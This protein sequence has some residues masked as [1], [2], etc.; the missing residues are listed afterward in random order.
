MSHNRWSGCNRPAAAVAQEKSDRVLKDACVSQQPPDQRSAPH[1]RLLR[2]AEQIVVGTTVAAA[3]VAMSAYWFSVG[4]HQGRL[5]D[6]DRA[7]PLTAEFKVDVNE[8]HWPEL[9]QLP[10]IGETLA[11]RIVDARATS[12]PFVDHDDLRERVSGIG[13]VKLETLRPYL[14][15]M[16]NVEVVA[17]N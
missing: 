15:D 16:P 6:I 5:I 9:A 7:E 13:H 10:G 17:G 4:G 11:R 8:A 2:R 12:G 14:L 3:L 1:A